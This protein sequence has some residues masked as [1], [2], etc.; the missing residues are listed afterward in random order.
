MN[1]LIVQ[2]QENFNSFL[3]K[4]VL[5]HRYYHDV[6]VTDRFNIAAT[7]NLLIDWADY[8]IKEEKIDLSSKKILNYSLKKDFKNEIPQLQKTYIEKILFQ[9]CPLKTLKEEVFKFNGEFF[10]KKK[11]EDFGLAHTHRVIYQACKSILMGKYAEIGSHAGNSALTAAFANPKLEIY[12]YDNPNT[13]WG[14]QPNTDSKLKEN[15]SKI[16]NKSFAYFGNSHSD[17]IKKSI[18]E[19]AP[20]DIFLVD[21]DHWGDGAYKDL[22]LAY[23]SIKHDRILI[24]DDIV[25]HSYLEETFD[26]FVEHY[27]PQKSIKILKLKEDEVYNGYELRGVGIIIK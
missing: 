16:P 9:D 13:G 12:C 21:G 26:R 3:I 8:I 24:F 6:L 23:S 19:N 14:G 15:L 11:V 1:I 10:G 27:R 17:I 20:Y 2:R 18:I 25:H 4:T 7:K 5:K 22:E